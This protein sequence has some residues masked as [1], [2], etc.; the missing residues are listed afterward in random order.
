MKTGHYIV[1]YLIGMGAVNPAVATGAPE[2]TTP[3]SSPSGTV[4]ASLGGLSVT[5]TYLELTPGSVGLGQVKLVV[6]LDVTSGLLNFTV[7]VGNATSNMCLIAVG[8]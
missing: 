8:K 5:P 6:P 3:L 7:T 2:P 4:S 1:A